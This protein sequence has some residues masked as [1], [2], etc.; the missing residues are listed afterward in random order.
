MPH[1]KISPNGD[2]LIPYYGRSVRK[3]RLSMD[4]KRVITERLSAKYRA[5]RKHRQRSQILDEVVELTDYERHYAAWLL[6][7]MGK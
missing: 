3:M 1:L 5:C 2:G 6:R 4:Q 7:N